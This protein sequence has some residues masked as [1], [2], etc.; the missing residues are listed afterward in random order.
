MIK[1]MRVQNF[2]NLA[3]VQ[4]EFSPLNV[5]IG[6][7]GCG[8]TSL[9]QSIDF[10]RAFFYPSIELYLDE[11]GFDYNDLPNLQTSSKSMQWELDVE[12]PSDKDGFGAGRY[13]YEVS[14]RKSKY[15][16]L[17]REILI[18]TSLEGEEKPLIEMSKRKPT[19]L[20]L[21]DSEGGRT[22]IVYSDINIRMPRSYMADIP[23][24]QKERHPEIF[25]FVNW[26]KN[27][28]YFMINP[29][30]L[31]WKSRGPSEEI[32][33]YGE[34]LASFLH[35]MKRK[36]PGKYEQLIKKMKRI[37]PSVS[38][39]DV[40]GSGGMG[41]NEIQQLEKANRNINIKSEHMSDG[42]LR[43]LAMCTFLYSDDAPSIIN[44]EEIENG[45]HPQLIREVIRMLSDLTAKKA[46]APQIFITTHNPYVL[47]EFIDKPQ[48][49]YVM[50][51]GLPQTGAQLF[52]LSEN[53]HIDVV[54]ATYKNSLG[55]AWFSG[56]IGGT[57]KGSIPWE[58]GSG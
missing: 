36:A 51:R 50:E 28:R 30:N 5:I 44:I 34:F 27:I 1:W 43:M 54:K 15:L 55:E 29:N 49:V 13:H 14:I 4:A 10:L 31:R 42:V 45:I 21:P 35:S 24:K 9:L 52:R 38:G 16:G 3:D 19:S 46:H 11:K 8:K 26:I 47:D 23:D 22:Q 40:K 17:D 25:N 32:G 39:I 37:F 56:L 2:K 20:T 33:Q 7:N 41:W 18:Y 48:Q 57:A 6:P 58:S 53:K 12:L